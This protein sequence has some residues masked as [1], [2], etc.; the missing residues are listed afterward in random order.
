MRYYITMFGLFC[1]GTFSAY[2][3]LLGVND[4]NHPLVPLGWIGICMVGFSMVV[5][6]IIT[7][8]Y[9]EK[10]CST[11]SSQSQQDEDFLGQ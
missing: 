9:E 4:S 8:H 6:Y 2:L 11:K 5:M 3:V 10:Q 1:I 7:N